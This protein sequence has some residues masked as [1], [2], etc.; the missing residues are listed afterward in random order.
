MRFVKSFIEW[1]VLVQDLPSN[2]PSLWRLFPRCRPGGEHGSAH[3]NGLRSAVES[4]SMLLLNKQKHSYT[5]SLGSPG[6]LVPLDQQLGIIAHA[7]MPKPF[8]SI[9]LIGLCFRFEL[10]NQDWSCNK[11]IETRSF[12]QACAERGDDSRYEIETRTA[13]VAVPAILS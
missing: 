12:R 7:L 13:F 9:A 5:H 11:T 8:G 3:E 1:C 4:G 6:G 2:G 10:S